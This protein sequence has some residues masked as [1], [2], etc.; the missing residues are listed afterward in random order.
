VNSQWKNSSPNNYGSVSFGYLSTNTTF[1]FKL[2]FEYTSLIN[3]YNYRALSLPGNRIT[4]IQDNSGNST[5]NILNYTFGL[6]KFSYN[7]RIFYITPEFS[8]RQIIQN[9]STFSNSTGIPSGTVSFENGS[10]Y[11]NMNGFHP[12]AGFS[13]GFHLPFLGNS[14]IFW[15][16]ELAILNSLPGFSNKL[17]Y[18]YVVLDNSGSLRYAQGNGN[19]GLSS[20]RF[21]MGLSY[22]LETIGFKIGF[23]NEMIYSKIHSTNEIPL[24]ITINSVS[25]STLEAISNNSLV[26]NTNSKTY[27]KTFYFGISRSLDLSFSKEED[28]K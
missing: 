18:N 6:N 22:F 17:N 5:I 23:R 27:Y 2:Q 19:F 8:I 9:I 15:M 25:F 21:E 7:G 12:S 16:Y 1:P 11:F 13:G 3:R 14:N 20:Q 24:Y 4:G 28:K 10:K 26:Y